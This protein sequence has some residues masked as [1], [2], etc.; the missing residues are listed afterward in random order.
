MPKDEYSS[1]G[2]GALKLKGAKDAGIDKK[3]KKKKPKPDSGSGEASSSKD[4]T[5]SKRTEAK[6]NDTQI[7]SGDAED[8]P[9]PEVFKTE[10]E[11]RH[12]EMRRKRVG[13]I[14]GVCYA[15]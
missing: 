6:G 4:T 13:W 9:P 15:H 8:L 12:D 2:G 5:D 7:I 11:R 14:C 10:A 3:R 1:V